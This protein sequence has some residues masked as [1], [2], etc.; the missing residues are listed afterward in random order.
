MKIALHHN[1]LDNV[2][3]AERVT[4]IL[5]R[6]LQADIYTTNINKKNNA[7][8]NGVARIRS[9]GT[10]PAQAPFRQQLALLRF[11]LFQT[12]KQY[13]A[14][15]ITGDWAVSAA[16]RNKPTI[17][18]VHSPIRE[19]WDLYTHT[20]K[21]VVPLW[22]RPL[23]D[24]WVLLNRY[25]NKKYVQQVD[26]IVCN[27]ENV[28]RRVQKYLGRGAIVIHPPT[29]TKQFSYKK[30]GD[31]WLSVNRLTKHKRIE[32]QLKA[33]AKLPHEKLI[34]VGSYEQAKHFLAEKKRLEKIKPPNVTILHHVDDK[35]LKELYTTCKG[36]I[37][38][39]K[40]EDFGLTPIE[41]M[42]SGKPVIAPREGG[43]LETIIDK[44]TGILIQDITVEKLIE[45]IKIIGK[46]PSAYR[47]ACESQAKKFDTSVFIQKMR[48]EI[49]RVTTYNNKNKVST[50]QTYR[51]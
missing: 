40:N 48:K 30:N 31:F 36:F 9:I 1:Y 33:F 26:S 27:S 11:R 24:L 17:W 49:Q 32:L 42:A 23:F 35:K 19:I 20:R 8:M 3:G 38:T 39:S 25:L 43:Y 28:R 51:H 7:K 29:D 46:N 21:Y 6:E 15:I 45:A 18:Y 4:H 44:K 22:Q 5:A 14:H 13:D 41:A 10:I 37:S 47:Y 16:K 34:I 50:K 2:G 12:K